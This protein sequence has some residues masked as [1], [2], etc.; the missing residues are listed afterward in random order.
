MDIYINMNIDKYDKLCRHLVEIEKPSS[1]TWA[2]TTSI[3]HTNIQ[4]WDIAIM[5]ASRTKGCR[6]KYI[7]MGHN[8]T[9]VYFISKFSSS[10]AS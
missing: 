9:I 1:S 7:T 5:V 4:A 8:S 10:N 6:L 2:S 3:L